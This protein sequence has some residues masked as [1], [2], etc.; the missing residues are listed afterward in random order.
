MSN[1]L[2]LR[3]TLVTAPQFEPVTVAEAKL[4]ARIDEDETAIASLIATAREM[5]ET[6]TRRAFVTQT[7]KMFLDQFPACSVIEMPRAPLQSVTH[8]KTYDDADA[9]TTFAASNYYVDAATRPGRIV[10]RDASSWPDA[11]RVANAV[12]IQFV[13]GYGGVSLVPAQIKQAVL[14]TVAHLYEH[15]GDATMDLPETAC[16]LLSAHKDW[17]V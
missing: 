12:E 17:M 6:Y 1:A 8:I 5:A 15:R 7:W 9:A 3:L 4:H 11:D 2:P 14:L 10:L 13:A 16:V